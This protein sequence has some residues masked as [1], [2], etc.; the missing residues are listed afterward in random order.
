MS[1]AINQHLVR[2][3][4]VSAVINAAFSFGIT[5]LLL[6]GNE[7][8][9]RQALV[10]DALPQ[11][12]FVTFFGVCIPTLLARKK[13]WAGKLASLP[14]RKTWL[15]G[16]AM[17]RAIL[18]GV[19]A[20]I[21]GGLLHWLVLSGLQITQLAIGAVYVYKTLYGAALSLVVTPVALLVALKETGNTL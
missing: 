18:M 6:G 5:H 11:S 19:I 14:Y 13:M 12:F 20:A 4:G 17:L 16:N 7:V 3:T 15:P 2:E 1:S 9:T 21:A 10:I 8:I